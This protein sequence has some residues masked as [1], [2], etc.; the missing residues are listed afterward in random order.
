MPCRNGHGTLKLRSLGIV[1]KRS[2]NADKLTKDDWEKWKDVEHLLVARRF[3]S[4][5]IFVCPQ[6]TYAERL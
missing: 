4:D 1:L 5:V 3:E 6:C 2:I